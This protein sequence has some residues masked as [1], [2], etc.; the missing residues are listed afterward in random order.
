[1]AADGNPRMAI[2]RSE[3]PD[4]FAA[5][6]D[7]AMRARK[8]GKLTQPS[9]ALIFCTGK[10]DPSRLRER[11]RGVIG[12]ACKLVGGD[13]VG[14]IAREAASYGGYE[15]GAALLELDGIALDA[16]S[17][18]CPG[19]EAR[20]G[21]LPGQKPASAGA[22]APENGGTAAPMPRADV[23]RLWGPSS[24]RPCT[25]ALPHCS[26]GGAGRRG[27]GEIVPP[28]FRGWPFGVLAKRNRRR[29]ASVRTAGPLSGRDRR[30]KSPRCCCRWCCARRCRV[31]CRASP[32]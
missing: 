7:A 22:T 25:T 13:A 10:H 17:E 18:D 3:K 26:A 32:R 4:S 29:S 15:V 16:V 12:G 2:G 11:V 1:M 28:I 20:A 9:L 27:D 8:I 5:G 21:E 24:R 14:V 23:E 30:G 19:A 31:S 6:K